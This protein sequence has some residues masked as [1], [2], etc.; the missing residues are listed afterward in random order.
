[1]PKCGRKTKSFTRS[2]SPRKF[3][4]DP[5]RRTI[6]LLALAAIVALN[7]TTGPEEI[8]LNAKHLH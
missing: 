2:I 7:K 5:G 8:V 4:R 3:A 1:L 6:L